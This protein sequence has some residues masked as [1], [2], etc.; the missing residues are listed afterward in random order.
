MRYESEHIDLLYKA[1]CEKLLED[2][3]YIISPR[4]MKCHEIINAKLV[5][6]DPTSRIITL[7]SRKFS[8][9]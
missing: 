3:D 1:I 7:P 9:R 8:K 6:Y 5:L 2:P 4:E